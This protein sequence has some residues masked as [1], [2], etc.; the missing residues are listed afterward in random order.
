VLLFDFSRD[1]EGGIHGIAVENNLLPSSSRTFKLFGFQRYGIK[2]FDTYEP[3]A[4]VVRYAIPIGQFT[5]GNN[6]SS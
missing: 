1:S 5:A 2:D 6:P 3:G 4:G